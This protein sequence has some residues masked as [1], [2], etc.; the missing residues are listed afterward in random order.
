MTLK[1]LSNLKYQYDIKKSPSVPEYAVPRYTFTDK[2]A[3]GLTKAIK[4][5]CDIKGIFCQRTGN[6]GRY[7]PGQSVVDAIGRTRIMKGTWLPGLNNGQADVTLLL[8]GRY[9]AVE[10]KIGKDRQSQD[11]KDFEK[12]IKSSGGHY[13]IVRTWQEFYEKFMF[14]G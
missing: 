14:R 2:T 7:R 8:D 13:W 1:D 6:E 5:F 11:Q 4:T 12:S 10:I 9:V 3:N